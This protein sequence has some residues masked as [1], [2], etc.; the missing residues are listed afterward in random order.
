MEEIL[1]G[2]IGEEEKK[3][4]V[5]TDSSNTLINANPLIIIFVIIC[6][7]HIS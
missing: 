2:E 4:K 6:T 7:V 1:G 5:V 3:I